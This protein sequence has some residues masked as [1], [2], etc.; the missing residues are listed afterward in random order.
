VARGVVLISFRYHLVTIV[1][2]FLALALGLLAGTTVVDQGLV[3]RLEAQTRQANDAAEFLREERD[4]LQSRI[5]RVDALAATAVPPLVEGRLQ[6]QRFL[7]LADQSSKTT[8]Q[9]RGTLEEAGGVLVASMFFTDRVQ[10]EE[11]HRELAD[12]LGLPQDTDAATLQEELAQRIADRFLGLDFGS[13]DLLIQLLDAGFLEAGRGSGLNKVDGRLSGIGGRGQL[14]L[15]LQG[16]PESTYQQL[17][18]SVFLDFAAG[19]G[20]AAVAEP[21]L[22]T[23]GVVGF[24]RRT[25]APDSWVSVDNVDESIGQIS[26][27]VGL[28]RLLESGQGGD[29]GFKPGRDS[30]MPPLER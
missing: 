27:A 11:A 12:I 22:A 21:S 6:G 18:A 25:T 17:L 3:N 14:L 10:D 23:D 4:Y 5:D 20:D 26:L 9:V 1:A 16:E 28:Q 24:V 15:A 2:V 29:F 13:E 7:I 8:D 19:G 30:L